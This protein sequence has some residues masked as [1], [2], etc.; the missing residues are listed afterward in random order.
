MA[1]FATHEGPLAHV[2][3][4]LQGNTSQLQAQLLEAQAHARNQCNIKILFL[5]RLFR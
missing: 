2:I 3:N 4:W 5:Q 1:P